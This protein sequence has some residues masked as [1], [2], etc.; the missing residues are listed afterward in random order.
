MKTSNYRHIASHQLKADNHRRIRSSSRFVQVVP[1]TFRGHKLER[2]A[3]GTSF[4]PPALRNL[5]GTQL[6]KRFHASNGVS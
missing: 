5:V 6:P 4:V 1:R 3:T 2:P